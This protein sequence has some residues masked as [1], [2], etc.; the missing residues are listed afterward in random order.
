M[1]LTIFCTAIITVLNSHYIPQENNKQLTLYYVPC[2]NILEY[3]IC[4]SSCGTMITLYT[5][6]YKLWGCKQ[7]A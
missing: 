3:I 5:L 1:I 4:I 7:L 2:G 6:Y